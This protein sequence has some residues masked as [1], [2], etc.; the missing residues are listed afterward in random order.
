MYTYIC[1]KSEIFFIKLINK[2]HSDG[3]YIL[4]VKHVYSN[5]RYI[6]IITKYI[7]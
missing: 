2:I 5:Y 1:N 4:K 3:L 7:K 6:N